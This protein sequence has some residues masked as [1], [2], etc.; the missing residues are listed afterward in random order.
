MSSVHPAQPTGDASCKSKRVQ[1]LPPPRVVCGL[2]ST[3]EG[4]LEAENTAM[5]KSLLRAATSSTAA[6]DPER[7]SASPLQGLPPF[8]TLSCPPKRSDAVL[9]L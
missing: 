1:I 5:R 3:K 7:S 4:G 8:R 9:S 6:E 2:L